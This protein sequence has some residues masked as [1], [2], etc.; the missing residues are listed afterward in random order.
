MIFK[1]KTPTT[2]TESL[3]LKK[4]TSENGNLLVLHVHSL[5]NQG[6]LNF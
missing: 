4:K 6:V 5:R 2:F 3:S 1:I